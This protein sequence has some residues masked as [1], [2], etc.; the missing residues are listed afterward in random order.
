MEHLLAMYLP[1]EAGQPP[2]DEEEE[3][4]DEE[5]EEELTNGEE[6][7][8]NGETEDSLPNDVYAGS[9]ESANTQRDNTQRLLR[10]K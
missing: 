3:E 7:L 1:P 9:R 6:E 5:E 4:E 2:E 10:C 8:T